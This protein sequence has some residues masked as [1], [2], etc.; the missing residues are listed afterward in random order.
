MHC[1]GGYITTTM[2]VG[3][4]FL[5]SQLAEYIIGPGEVCPTCR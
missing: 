4:K 1:P 3:G 2:F 5:W